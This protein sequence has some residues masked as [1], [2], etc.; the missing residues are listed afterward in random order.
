MMKIIEGSGENLGKKVE[1]NLIK[2]SSL[3]K[4]EEGLI[5]PI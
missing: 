5:E 1:Q 3:I 4:K 2:F